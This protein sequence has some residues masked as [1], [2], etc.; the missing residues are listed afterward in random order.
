MSRLEGLVALDDADW[1]AALGA[2]GLPFR[3]SHRAAAGRALETA[4]P[5]YRYS[6]YRADYGDGSSLLFPLVEVRRQLRSLSMLQGMPFGLEGTPLPLAG[7]TQAA[8]VEALFRELGSHGALAL[9]GGAGGSPP[10]LGQVTHAA[11]G[12]GRA[13]H[14]IVHGEEPQRVPQGRARG[15]DGRG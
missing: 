9:Y 8:H 4:I 13:R 3:F 2:T 15:R 1:D 14:P 11:G 10:A 5:S 12:S 6:P 7:A